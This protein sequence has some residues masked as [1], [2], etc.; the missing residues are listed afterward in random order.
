MALEESLE[1][2][3]N[4]GI[5]VSRGSGHS[6][7]LKL[8]EMT[9]NW[10]LGAAI[11]LTSAGKGKLAAK[12][13][14]LAGIA[15]MKGFPELVEIDK[16]YDDQYDY[17]V[18]NDGKWCNVEPIQKGTE[19]AVVIK[20]N[21][22][23]AIG[24]EI[25]G[26]AGFFVPSQI[27]VAQVSTV[28]TVADSAGSLN[29][30]YFLI[31]GIDTNGDEVEYYVW[32]N[33]NSAGTD[34]KLDG[35]I[36]VPIA[37]ATNATANTLATAIATALDALAVFGAAEVT[38]TVTVTNAF[39]GECID[40]VDSLT[41]PT[42]FTIATTTQGA[43]AIGEITNPTSVGGINKLTKTATGGTQK[44]TIMEGR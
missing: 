29:D 15:I 8:L 22:A 43:D 42:G 9:E 6:T 14:P 28:Q 26:D 38:D 40:P 44:Y 5:I 21:T 18:E 27:G 33:I 1:S 31:S 2:F 12:G 39:R 30:T 4:S 7:Q 16:D 10:W 35:K 24:A 36:A 23:A 41:A 37:G 20:T 32:F 3:N 11:S 17:T 25:Q 13:E 34:P 19:Y